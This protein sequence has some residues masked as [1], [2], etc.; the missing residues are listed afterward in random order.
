MN[1]GVGMEFILSIAGDFWKSALFIL[2]FLLVLGSIVFV[3]EFGHFIVGRLCGAVAKIFSLGIGPE[4]VGFDDR[5]GTRWRLSALPLGGYVKFAGDRNAA[6][7]A[8]PD[9]IAAMS[10]AERKMSF[11]GQKL[12][13]RAAIVAA[14]PLANF[15]FAILVFA[16]SAYVFGETRLVPR[17]ADVAPESAAAQAGFK[18]GDIVK[19]I[20]GE[21]VDSFQDLSQTV[22]GKGG[23]RL[24]IVV[25]RDEQELTLVAT[26]VLAMV[27]SP[28][29][30]E[31]R[32]YL[33]LQSSSD[34]KDLSTS[35]PGILAALQIGAA[36]SWDIARQTGVYVAHLVRGNETPAKL[37][38]PIRI[39]QL[40]NLVAASGIPALLNFAAL[41]S[42]SLGMINL[43]PVP[44]LDGGH[45]L[46]YA[47]EAV[48]GKP[49]GRKAQELSLR[50][51]V[52]FVMGLMILVTVNDIWRILSP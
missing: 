1:S 30:R 16:A 25:E 43:V 24:S 9:A 38:G 12:P 3:H 46:F 18:A 6:G 15:L 19:S 34:P 40:S 45:L 14:G 17:V 23:Q 27:D 33:G 35:Y 49:L 41:L 31:N 20:D 47:I 50:I 4:L 22:A 13:C 48:R 11:A 52:A 42:V 51:G 44:I 37:S 28:L 2:P 32:G 7:A 8:D 10:D 36:R 26:P 21:P 39:A 5:R 29:G